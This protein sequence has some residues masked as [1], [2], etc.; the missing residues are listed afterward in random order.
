M[1][2]LFIHEKEK[3]TVEQEIPYRLGRGPCHIQNLA[4]P[5]APVLS[6]KKCQ[7]SAKITPKENAAAMVMY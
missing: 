4:H 7:S 2:L 6:A 5:T 1:Q 3:F